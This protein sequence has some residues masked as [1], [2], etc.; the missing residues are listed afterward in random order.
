M[1]N[2]LN[3]FKYLYSWAN[4]SKSWDFTCISSWK[5]ICLVWK[6]WQRNRYRSRSKLRSRLNKRIDILKPSIPKYQSLQWR[7]C[8]IVSKMCR[9]QKPRCEEKWLQ[10]RFFLRVNTYPTYSLS[11]L[12]CLIQLLQLTTPKY[13]TLVF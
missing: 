4:I 12:P 3:P 13:A 5:W 9:D 7:W 10:P 2:I 1:L 6:S 8:G 11:K